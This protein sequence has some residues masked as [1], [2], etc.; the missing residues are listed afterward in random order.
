MTY[1]ANIPQDLPP[2]SVIV[3]QIR[4]NFSTFAS[5]F[6]NNHQALNL[7]NQGK[8][9]NVILQVGTTGSPPVDDNS[10]RLYTFGVQSNSSFSRQLFLKIPKFLPNDQPND[11]IQ[12]TF[13][14]VNTAG[15]LYQSFLI[16]GFLVFIGTANQPINP[17][18]IVPITI[19]LT[20]VPKDILCIIANVNGSGIGFQGTVS[21]KAVG[22]S[23]I[24]ITPGQ[25]N[26][27]ATQPYTWLAI[28]GQ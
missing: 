13:N 8:H 24:V 14:S 22:N 10:N 20:P 17:N 25:P 26:S 5:V 3:D 15:P 23:Q 11:P 4:E 1:K 21:A 19:N 16:G 9:T 27:G 28:C 12:L 6:D 2:P 7:N 18:T